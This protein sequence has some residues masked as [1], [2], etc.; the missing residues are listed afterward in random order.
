MRY[1]YLKTK[2]PWV[3]ALVAGGLILAA[4]SSG[5]A[6]IANTVHNLGAGGA[7]ANAGGPNHLYNTATTEIC[8][9]CHTPHGAAAG[10]TAPL[11]NKT[12]SAAASYTTYASLGTSTL[13]GDTEPVGSVSIACLSCHDG[14]QTIEVM[15]NEPGGGA[16]TITDI[17]WAAGWAGEMG[18]AGEYGPD[19]IALMGTDLSNDHPIG[20]Q[21]GGGGLSDGAPTAATADPD[22]IAPSNAIINGQTVWWVDTAIGGSSARQKTDMQLYTRVSTV[23]AIV[24][25]YV[26]C[27]S[28]HDP[29]A[30]TETFLRISNDGSAVCLACHTK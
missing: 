24:Q 17:E 25:P 10:V 15:I 22:F 5:I 21:Y 26:E 7:T 1:Q 2:R 3:S 4:S 20:I 29:H 28:C 14:T 27:A 6:G 9:F 13:E 16:D 8:V 19:G 23:G 12:V 11:W 30:E 18:L